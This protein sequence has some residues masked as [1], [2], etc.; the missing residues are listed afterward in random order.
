MRDYILVLLIILS[1]K[2]VYFGLIHART[3][4]SLFGIILIICMFFM[5]ENKLKFNAQNAYLF[6]AVFMLAVIQAALNLSNVN[7]AYINTAIVTYMP[8]L[9]GLL[10]AKL[11]TDE[12]YIE[13]YVNIFSIISIISLICFAIAVYKPI[14]AWV[15]SK[16][17]LFNDHLYNISPFYTWGWNTHIFSRNS[18]PFWEP[19]AYQGF[20]LIGMLFILFRKERITRFARVKFILLLITML[21]TASTTGYIATIIMVLFLYR[22]I[23]NLLVKNK[24]RR[25][26]LILKGF[27]AILV[28]GVVLF[29]AF[30][31]NI[32]EKFSDTNI[33]GL[34][35]QR[36]ITKSF[37][38]VLDRPVFGYAFTNARSIRQSQLGIENN[39]AGLFILMYTCGLP[40]TIYYLFLMFRGVA[41]YMKP[42][43]SL[44]KTVL[45]IFMIILHLTES[46]W[47]LPVYVMFLYKNKELQAGDKQ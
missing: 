38:M 1:S 19:G 11:I 13:K 30:S 44:E 4:Y 23:E 7:A 6:I 8:F 21:T 33:S 2:T 22:R 40:F 9:F 43:N 37:A 31:G 39:S 35:R 29:I 26:R 28:V 15:I 34:T 3:T 45:F 18:G 47:W 46:V 24:K 41:R 14:I 17:V 25:D 5:G 10:L 12:S 36:D 27:I 16:Q 32:G 20:L 42:D